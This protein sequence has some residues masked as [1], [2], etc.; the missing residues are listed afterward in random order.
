VLTTSVEDPTYLAEA[1]VVS[2]TFRKES[3]L[4]HWAP[5]PCHS[6]DPLEPPVSG[7]R[8]R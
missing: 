5:G 8:A 2:T 1:F 3:D 4:S 7:G 6:D